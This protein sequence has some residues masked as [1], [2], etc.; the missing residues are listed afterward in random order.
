MIR[1]AASTA[2]LALAPVV[3]W[4]APVT[5]P[6]TP[7]AAPPGPGA[8]IAMH[9][10]LFQ[11]LDAGDLDKTLALLHPDMN[12][13]QNE[14]ARPCSLFLVDRAGAPR[15]AN[16]FGASK[17]LL[18]EW[19]PAWTPDGAKCETRITPI[20]ADCF[21]AE[22]SYAVLELERKVTLGGKTTTQRYVSTSLVTYANDGW[23]LTHWHLSPADANSIAGLATK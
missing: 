10:R 13:N 12:M 8:V 2:L 4:L 17:K 20:G 1:S 23:Q 11:A 5:P 19:L 21:S 14:R 6:V 7:V 16:G 22:L 3:L 15:Q 18:G 9:D